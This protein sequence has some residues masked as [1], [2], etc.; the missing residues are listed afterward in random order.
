[1]ADEYEFTEGDLRPFF[2]VIIKN[3]LTNGVVDLTGATVTFYFR[4]KNAQTAKVSAGACTITDA[5]AGKVEYRWASGD[6]SVPGVYNAVFLITHT[7]TKP[8]S[9][10]IENVVVHPKLG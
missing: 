1:M 5:A 9:V 2:A 8:Q 7:D 3:D 6:L 4:E 10:R